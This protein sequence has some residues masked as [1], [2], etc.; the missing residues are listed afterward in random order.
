MLK[1]SD[2]VSD[3]NFSVGRQPQVEIDG[4]L[5]PVNFPGLPRLTPYQ[6]EMIAMHMMRGDREATR[7]L[8]KSGSVDISYSIP[9][10]TRFRVNIF[11]SAAR[12]PSSFASFRRGSPASSR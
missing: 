6:T 9:G 11:R 10:K 7:T 3:L 2:R 1:M 12:T 5:A 8:L 4:Q